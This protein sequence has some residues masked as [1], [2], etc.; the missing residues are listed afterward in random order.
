MSDEVKTYLIENAFFLPKNHYYLQHELTYATRTYDLCVHKS[1]SNHIVLKCDIFNHQTNGFYINYLDNKLEQIQ[2]IC[3]GITV[4][5][6][7]KLQIQLLMSSNDYLPLNLS[8]NA[9][10]VTNIAYN[11]R[12]NFKDIK[13]TT[14]KLIFNDKQHSLS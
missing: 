11:C 7:D 3:D 1:D 9:C 8:I 2:I 10:D 13:D 4:M 6:Y 12:I 14:I 5:E